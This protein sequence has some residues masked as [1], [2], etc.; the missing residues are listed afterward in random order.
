MAQGRQFAVLD[1]E[2]QKLLLA[3]LRKGVAPSIAV[4]KARISY[5]SF[6]NGMNT[7]L[8][9]L[10]LLESGEATEGDMDDVDRALV[11]FYYKVREAEYQAAEA[12]HDRITTAGEADWR[13]AAWILA[14]RFPEEYLEKS[15]KDLNVQGNI[16]GDWKTIVQTAIAEAGEVDEADKD[17]FE[18]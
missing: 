11:E 14:R 1:P 9:I 3:A 16:S 15:S 17:S 12:Y 4:R 8:E 2:R 13:A 18:E 7:A 6:Q 5:P 10:D